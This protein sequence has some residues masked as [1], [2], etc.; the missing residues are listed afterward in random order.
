MEVQVVVGG[1]VQKKRGIARQEWHP[2]KRWGC[3]IASRQAGKYEPTAHLDAGVSLQHKAAAAGRLDVSGVEPAKHNTAQH[4]IRGAAKVSSQALS[5]PEGTHNTGMP[6][7][8]HAQQTQICVRQA[9]MYPSRRPTLQGLQ[10]Q[11]KS[12]PRSHRSGCAPGVPSGTYA[13]LAS[14]ITV[15]STSPRIMPWLTRR[16]KGS[17]VLTYP[18]SNSTCTHTQRQAWWQRRVSIEI[19]IEWA[20]ECRGSMC[21]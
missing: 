1:G 8:K 21:E 7:P 14:C 12:W 3:T 19:G 18:M 13:P 4:S 5:L 20:V 2:P 9:G 11:A 15:Y 10:P 16:W 6:P 17:G